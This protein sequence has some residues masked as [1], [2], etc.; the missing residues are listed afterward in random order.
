MKTA[1]LIGGMG[2]QVTAYFYT[3]LIQQQVRQKEQNYLDIIIYS[4][5]SVPDRTA[6][7]LDNTKPNPCPALVAAAVSLEKA[8]ADFIVISCI[9]AHYFYNEISAAVNIPVVNALDVVKEYVESKGL[10][11][12]W[13]LATSGTIKSQLLVVPKE[14][15]IH[16]LPE[17]KQAELMDIIYTVKTATD[18]TEPRL[19]LKKLISSVRHCGLNPQSNRIYNCD[20]I[21]GQ[22]RNDVASHY[23][24]ILGCT[25]LSLIAEPGHIDVLELLVQKTL[26]LGLLSP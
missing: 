22:A 15:K 1:G 8:G 2:A 7:I 11:D 6:Y 5:T 23:P 21:A 16:T 24:V 13:L 26:Q 14:T 4:K 18:L 19:R 25:E 20:G 10:S 9:T 17:D 3:K 12:V